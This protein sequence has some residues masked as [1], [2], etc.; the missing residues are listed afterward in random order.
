MKY[1]K[2]AAYA[3]LA[4][5][6]VFMYANIVYA[7]Q[8]FRALVGRVNRQVIL[9]L[10]GIAATIAILIFIWGLIK[11]IARAGDETARKE[12]KQTIIWG[13]VVFFIAASLFGIVTLLQRTFFP[14]G[15]DGPFELEDIQNDDGGINPTNPGGGPT[16][17]F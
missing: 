4:L 17:P 1:S 14:G 11:L 9:P 6:N 16:V 13:I 12:G 8:D 2:Y 15:A 10:L 3:L 5:L 7:Q